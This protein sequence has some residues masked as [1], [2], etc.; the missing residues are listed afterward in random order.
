MS[1]KLQH[2]AP[3][4]KVIYIDST[5]ADVYLTYKNGLPLTS[6]F[7]V[8]FPDAIT[9]EE[10]V[11]CLISLHS[12]SI[13]YSF[14]NT[15]DEINDRID[16]YFGTESNFETDKVLS[17]IEIPEG[18]YT[19]S[20][21]L[22]QMA[23][24]L[25][26]KINT[27]TIGATTN[28]VVDFLFYYLKSKQKA[29]LSFDAVKMSTNNWKIQFLFDTG[30]NIS[31]GVMGELGFRRTDTQ[32]F[33][34]DSSGNV[35]CSIEFRSGIT[36]TSIT[37]QELMFLTPHAIDMSNSVRG[38]YVRT[39][40]TT[41]S[42]MDTQTSNF[43]KILSRIP[44]TVNAGGV[45]FHEPKN[46]T[47]KALLKLSTVKTIIIRL[48]DE[49]NRLLDLN[50]LNFQVAIQ[51]DFIYNQKKIPGLTRFER[52]FVSHYTDRAKIPEII[53]KMRKNQSVAGDIDINKFIKDYPQYQDNKYVKDALLLKSSKIKKNKTNK[54]I[55]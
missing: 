42:T 4:S 6:H 39:N 28:I 55:K 46:S 12:A 13:P 38:V 11:D 24:E 2:N 50:G 41:T 44:I 51:I 29:I 33:W 31:R 23:S 53:M 16:F 5:D 25:K 49:R 15:R 10:H 9:I 1:Y 3:A 40:L 32:S 20:S 7:T 19:V 21:L 48:T 30:V 54:K 18:N 52:R 22:I 14:Y 36:S 37:D 17:F 43:S 26:T 27:L 45:I 35:G 8:T 34:I 47:H